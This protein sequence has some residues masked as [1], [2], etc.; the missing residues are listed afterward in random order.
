MIRRLGTIL[1]AVLLS[2]VASG[3]VASGA[4]AVPTATD[5]EYVYD[6][7]IYDAPGKDTAPE[8]GPPAA[9]S[10]G[11]TYDAVDIRSNWPSARQN[12]PRPRGTYHY[13][14]TRLLVQRDIAAR[15]TSRSAMAHNGDRSVFERTLVAANTVDKHP[16]YPR[17]GSTK[18]Q[19]L[20]DNLYKGT[21]NPNRVGNGTTIDAIRNEIAT[22]VPTAGRMH[23]IKGQETL[24]GLN[25][26]LRRNPGAD[27]HDRL[28]G[29]SLAGELSLVLRGGG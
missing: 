21:T 25:N 6:A 23:T 8:R 16:A 29:Q 15:T 12:G 14:D 17:V 1:S 20:V 26:W 2:L 13:D 19:N 18:L 11:T 3:G 5:G 24:N 10:E 7:Q 27:Y 28:V 9:G 22:G 4:T